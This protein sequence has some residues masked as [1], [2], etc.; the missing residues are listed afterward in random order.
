MD[1]DTDVEAAYR[2]ADEGGV[3]AADRL[4]AMTDVGVHG[5]RTTLG[6]LT[7]DTPADAA[8]VGVELRGDTTDRVLVVF[9]DPD[10]VRHAAGDPDALPELGNV[11]VSGLVDGWADARETAID[12]APPARPDFAEERV[13]SARTV[14]ETDAGRITLLLEFVDDGPAGLRSSDRLAA[15]SA[16]SAADRIGGLTG[17]ETSVTVRE[18]TYL[19]V[20]GLVGDVD[21]E[22]MVAVAARFDGPPDG[23]FLLLLDEASAR[24]VARQ[25][26]GTTAL[27]SEGRDAIAEL[28]NVVAGG[29]V[30]SWAD[31]LG[32]AIDISPPQV[33][34]DIGEAVVDPVLVRLGRRQ[35]FAATFDA[36][37]EAAGG[38]FDCR[39]CA[40]SEGE[41]LA[42]LAPDT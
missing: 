13:P 27:D 29:V 30:D 34:H 24:A 25:L 42:P 10:A 18:L 23:Y 22:P 28:G 32:T 31:D 6:L 38:R 4:G 11:M 15:D 2:L 1:E 14:I 5:T 9:E 33:V 21:D 40:I 20:E 3:R 39:V 36:Q 17:V 35:S 8:V 7:P 26:A 37:V 12:M 16:A 41:G 19:P